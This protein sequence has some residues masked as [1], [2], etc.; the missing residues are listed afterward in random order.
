MTIVRRRLI[1][2]ACLLL[3]VVSVRW[4]LRAREPGAPTLIVVDAQHLDR[5]PSSS[6]GEVQ[7]ILEGIRLELDPT[8]AERD[9][10]EVATSGD[11]W[12][13]SLPKTSPAVYQRFIISP[14]T[15]AGTQLLRNEVLNP[16]DREIPRLEAE[17]VLA[18][19]ASQILVA[20]QARDLVN[21]TRRSLAYALD[22]AGQLPVYTPKA[23]ESMTFE[24]DGALVPGADLVRSARAGAG[25]RATEASVAVNALM[26]AGQCGPGSTVNIRGNRVSILPANVNN[27][28]IRDVTAVEKGVVLNIVGVM[29]NWFA[30]RGCCSNELIFEAASVIEDSSR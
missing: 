6:Q 29:H 15:V 14:C 8:K 18:W 9:A 22:R 24:K 1:L 11:S 3:G 5:V 21:K 7:S 13:A 25:P 12:W 27:K 23:L 26:L 28:E 16:G 4:L 20:Q 30:S 17:S 10:V 2:V 19:Y